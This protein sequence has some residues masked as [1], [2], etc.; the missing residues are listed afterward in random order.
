[1][2]HNSEKY[3]DGC[4]VRRVKSNKKQKFQQIPLPL[5][6]LAA[7]SNKQNYEKRSR[8]LFVIAEIVAIRLLENHQLHSSSV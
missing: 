1:M 3:E 8:N 7:T 6:L 5:K 2:L 4:T